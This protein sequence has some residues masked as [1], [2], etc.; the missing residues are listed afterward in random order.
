M[1]EI[2]ES[3]CE[4]G[5]HYFTDTSID[6]LID[7]LADDVVRE[8]AAKVL[9]RCV[10]EVDDTAAAALIQSADHIYYQ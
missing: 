9:R 6:V 7:D 3:T 5:I 1:S 8:T 10:I 2:M 4:L